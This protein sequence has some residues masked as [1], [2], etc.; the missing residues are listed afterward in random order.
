MSRSFAP[1]APIV[2]IDEKT[3]A[4]QLIW[5]EMDANATGDENVNL[6]IHPA[7]TSEGHTYVVAMRNLRN[8][9][10]RAIKAPKWFALLRDGRRLPKVERSQLGATS[11]SSRR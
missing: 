6:L 4:R 2:V 11:A 3:G 10:G 7:R 9:G 5:A 8:A 1:K